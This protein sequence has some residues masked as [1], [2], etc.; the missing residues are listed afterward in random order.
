M[1]TFQSPFILP[2]LRI[3]IEPLT[4][5]IL[6]LGAFPHFCCARHVLRFLI[7]LRLR[8]Q[9]AALF[10]ESHHGLPTC[11]SK[12]NKRSRYYRA[13]DSAARSSAAST[14]FFTDLI[15]HMFKAIHF[16]GTLF[17]N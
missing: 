8:F 14:A 9:A 5:I 2:I 7:N 11:Q 3:F 1:I 16:G 17:Q 13:C 4:F 10:S 6:A 15:V 12:R